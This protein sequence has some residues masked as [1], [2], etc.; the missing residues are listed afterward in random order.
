MLLGL[1]LSKGPIHWLLE[2]RPFVWLGDISYSVYLSHT[3][4]LNWFVMLSME[5]S[6]NASIFNIFAYIAIVLIFST[7]CYQLVEVPGRRLILRKFA[8]KGT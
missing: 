7:M 1:L 6:Q 8:S 5:D 2:L 4:L 3:V